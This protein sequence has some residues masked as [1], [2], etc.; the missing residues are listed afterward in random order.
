MDRSLMFES[1]N[2]N[3]GLAH[4][5]K[6]T[7]FGAG[8]SDGVT[9][10]FTGYDVSG[11]EAY[12]WTSDPLIDA[13]APS[14]WVQLDFFDIAKLSYTSTGGVDAGYAYG[15]GK[16]SHMVMDNFTFNEVPGAQNPPNGAPVPEPAT[17]LLLGIGIIGLAGIRK[18]FKF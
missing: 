2:E 14:E 6:I 11:D 18:K 3:N 8:W 4:A 9:V 1:K 10:S 13:S 5:T 17:M 15:G 12:S 16:M 7:A